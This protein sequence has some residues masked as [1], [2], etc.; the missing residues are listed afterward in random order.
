MADSEEKK[1]KKTRKRQRIEETIRAGD[2]WEPVGQTPMPGITDLRSW[3]MRL[4]KA[5][6]PHVRTL[7]RRLLLLHLRQV[8]PDRGAAGRV[9]HRHRRPAGAHR[10]AGRL[11]GAVGPRC[12]R[13]ACHRPPHRAPRRGP[14]DRPR[15][16]RGRGSP[17]HP[18]G[19]GA[20]AG[21]A[22]GP[23]DRRGIRR[24]RAD[25]P[26]LIAPH[27][28]GGQQPGLRVQGHARQH[29]G[30]RGHGSRR[31]RPDHR[32]QV[33]H[34]GGRHAAGGPGLRRSGRGQ[35]DDHSGGP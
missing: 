3:D 33:P 28:P 4:M 26:D 19:A 12:P 9:R 34:V 20:E 1:P 27:R 35:T 10:A 13:P 30:P 29:A 14:Q 11:H 24:G 22:E 7:L 21:D 6:P 2:A 16:Q 15:R 23:E 32:L 17:E 5:Y 18:A 25:T 31:Y 8:R